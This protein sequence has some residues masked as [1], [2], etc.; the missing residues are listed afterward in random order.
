MNMN[1]LAN[2]ITLVILLFSSSICNNLKSKK[3]Q[4]SQSDF[5]T[6][7]NTVLNAHTG[8]FKFCWKNAYGRGAGIIPTQCKNGG[9]YQAGLCYTRCQPGYQGVGPVCWEICPAGYRNDPASCFKSIFNWYFKKSYGR[10][11]G[12]IPTECQN[13]MEY[14]V[15]LCY[16]NCK[17]GYDGVGP[18]CWQLCLG[19]TSFNCG[20][21]CSDTKSGCISAVASMVKSVVEA[22]SNIT[23][24][25]GSFGGVAAIKTSA[26]AAVQV[27]IKAAKNFAKK[28][29]SAGNIKTVFKAAAKKAGQFI[30][31]TVVDKIVQG[32]LQQDASE[33]IAFSPE[34]LAGLDPTGIASAILSFKHAL[35]SSS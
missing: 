26:K 7:V 25:I 8:N 13:Q 23:E 34:D 10:G 19:E 2:F 24:I 21:G 4:A 18:I 3:A 5:L 16:N 31:D 9:E 6:A 20:M 28:G 30:K 17:P 15:G 14:D 32:T 29:L 33:M 12:L 27:A 1:S 22:I 11:V 35:C